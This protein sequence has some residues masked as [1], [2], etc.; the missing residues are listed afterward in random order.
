M[1]NFCVF[2]RTF[3]TEILEIFSEDRTSA[4][5]MINY[6][7]STLNDVIQNYYNETHLQ[8]AGGQPQRTYLRLPLMIP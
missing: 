2:V 8:F 1:T 5:K 4:R 6:C 7:K 3:P